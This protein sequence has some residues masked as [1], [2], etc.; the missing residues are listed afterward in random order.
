ML[1]AGSKKLDI[2]LGTRRVIA[3]EGEHVLSNVSVDGLEA[4]VDALQ[5]LLLS[6][7]RPL[8]LDIR[9]SGALCRPFRLPA[10]NGRQ[11]REDIV[12]LAQVIAEESTG[13]PGPYELWL[14]SG[15]KQPVC[16]VMHRDVL[17]AVQGR[18]FGSRNKIRLTALRPWW[19][20]VLEHSLRLNPQLK[21][22]VIRDCDSLA[23]LLGDAAGAFTHAACYSPAPIDTQSFLA[24]VLTAVSWSGDTV[25][26]AH[27][28]DQGLVFGR[29]AG[30]ASAQAED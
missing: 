10:L 20:E 18:M 23:L 11:S 21:G 15:A 14:E 7:T 25:A 9:L 22:L 27:L 26:E 8:R 1:W 3:A 6:Q 29:F 28:P 2:Y 16:V 5:T 17:Q 19:A 24:R 30:A 4:A 12:A 13:L